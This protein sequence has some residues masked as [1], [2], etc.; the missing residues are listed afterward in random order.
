MRRRTPRCSRLRAPRAWPAGFVQRTGRLTLTIWALSCLFFEILGPFNLLGEPFGLLALELG[1]WAVMALAAA[2]V[3][4]AILEHSAK[5]PSGAPEMTNKPN[6]IS[7]QSA[8]PIDD[9][10]DDTKD[11][12]QNAPAPNT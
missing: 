4:V 3:I 8:L 12:E 2:A 5:K 6:T 11:E 9:E 1:F 10:F 7:P